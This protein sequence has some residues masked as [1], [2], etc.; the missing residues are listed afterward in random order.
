MAQLSKFRSLIP[1]STWVALSLLSACQPATDPADEQNLANTK[2]PEYFVEPDTETSTPP[3][4]PGQTPLAGTETIYM[5]QIIAEYQAKDTYETNAVITRPLAV[6]DQKIYS[7]HGMLD[8]V[9]TQDGRVFFIGRNGPLSNGVSFWY[10]VHPKDQYFGEPLS[11]FRVKSG[12]CFVGKYISNLE[13]Y[14]VVPSETQNPVFEAF[15]LRT[16]PQWSGAC[17]QKMSNP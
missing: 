16:D 11:N 9:I 4:A 3:Q 5:Q 7:F 15:F 13:P 2:D 10:V 1:A 14:S 8:R 6:A 12:Y 17:I